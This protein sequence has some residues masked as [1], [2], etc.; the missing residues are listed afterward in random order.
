MIMRDFKFQTGEY[1]HIYNRGVEKRNIFCDE[2]DF[3]RFLTSMREFN[4]VDPIGSLYE[5]RT[6]L[7]AP[8]GLLEP[9]QIGSD[10]QTLRAR[11][12]LLGSSRPLVE[13]LCYSLANNH[14]HFILRQLVDNGISKFMLKLGMGY[15]NY[16]NT[17]NRRSG[18][19]FQGTYKAI[20]ITTNAYL[21]WLSGYINGNIE[22][23][24]MA[25]VKNWP[26]CSYLDY[27]GKR[28]GT[29]CSKN[30]I[31]EMVENDLAEYLSLVKNIIEESSFRKE[32]I[33]KFGFE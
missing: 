5:Q 18:S 13:F 33:K 12:G 10:S 14:Y 11:R 3:L 28:S 20:H 1:Y 22:I 7:R 31:M 26:W 15:T 30:I 32:E 29:L 6:V 23:H 2:K 24:K 27:A 17:K 8:V 4:R 25:K 16:F 19:L 9:C 21:L